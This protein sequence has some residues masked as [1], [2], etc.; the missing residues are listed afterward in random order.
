MK[1][2]ALVARWRV[3]LGYLVAAI[4]LWVARPN[5]LSI[6]LGAAIGLTGLGIR[7]WAAGY[8]HKQSVLTTGGPYAFT[9]N[10][11]YFGSAV[12]TA[13]AAVAMHSAVAA[14]LLF[15]YFVAVYWV[16]MRREEGELRLQHGAAFERYAASVPLLFPRLAPAGGGEGRFSLAQYRKNHE[17][18]AAAGFLLLLTV[19]LAIWWLRS[20]RF[21]HG[22]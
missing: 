3:R 1:G 6:A 10:P 11:L 20:G 12:L 2:A 18:Q 8:L 19:L 21:G 4:V 17:Y 7:A 5:P 22:I 9:R 14:I 13:G 15:V 16:V